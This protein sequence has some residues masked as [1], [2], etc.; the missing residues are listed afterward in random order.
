MKAQGRVV[1]F[2]RR[3]AVAGRPPPRNVVTL[4]RFGGPEPAAAPASD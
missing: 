4:S 3:V 1:R 2:E